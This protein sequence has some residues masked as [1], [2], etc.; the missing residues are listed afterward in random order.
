[1]VLQE[2]MERGPAPPQLYL[3]F[4]HV[5]E[6]GPQGAENSHPSNLLLTEHQVFSTVGPSASMDSTKHG[7]KKF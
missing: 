7:W 1:M 3:H 2:L 4:L 6:R 5:E